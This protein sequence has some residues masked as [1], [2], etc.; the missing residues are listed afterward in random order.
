MIDI[1]LTEAEFAMLVIAEDLDVFATLEDRLS[2]Y[3]PDFD[4]SGMKRIRDAFDAVKFCEKVCRADKQLGPLN[5]KEITERFSG[6]EG[7]FGYTFK[8]VGDTIEVWLD[9]TRVTSIKK[10]KL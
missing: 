7:E 5:A 6:V 9:E 8:T 2:D 10:G 1:S 3:Y 4:C